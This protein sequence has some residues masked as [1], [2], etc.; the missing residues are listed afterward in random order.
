VRDGALSVGYVRQPIK[1]A[2]IKTGVPFTDAERA[3]LDAFDRAA[4][5]VENTFAAMLEPGDVQF[6]NN[7]LVLH[8]RT[9]YEDWPEPGRERHMLRLWLKVD[10]IRPLDD[11]LIDLDPATGWSRREGILPRGMTMTDGRLVPV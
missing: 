1:T 5:R 3:A 8:S 7:H 10:G 6:C 2:R 9:A 4:A 11:G